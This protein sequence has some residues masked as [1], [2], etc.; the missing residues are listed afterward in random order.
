[1][2]GLDLLYAAAGVGLLLL[3]R[4]AMHRR[5]RLLAKAIEEEHRLRM[6]RAALEIVTDARCAV[7][8]AHVRQPRR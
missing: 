6:L 4:W 5:P 1:M 2:T 3:A 7:A 8:D